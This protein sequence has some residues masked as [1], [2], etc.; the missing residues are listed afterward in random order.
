M[1]LFARLADETR[2][3]AAFAYLDAEQRLLGLGHA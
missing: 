1:A 2:E 3:I